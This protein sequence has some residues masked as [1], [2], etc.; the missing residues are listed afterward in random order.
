MKEKLKTLLEKSHSPYSKVKV[1]SI[2]VDKN[3]NEYCG[4]NVENA[5]F[6]STICAER[7]AMLNAISSGAKAGEIKDVYIHSS[8]DGLKPCGACLQVMAE[9]LDEK[10]K[11]HIIGSKDEHYT[12]DELLPQHVKKDAFGWK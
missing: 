11:I 10:A 8:V 9:L 3:G 5:A 6:G 12:L 1:S 7:S 4:V 2:V